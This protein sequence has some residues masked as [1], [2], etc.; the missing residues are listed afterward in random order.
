MHKKSFPNGL[1]ISRMAILLWIFSMV[2]V[3]YLSLAPRVEPPLHFSYSDKVGHALAYLWLSALPYV[4][5]ERKKTALFGSLLMI[6][7][8]MGLEF[9]QY[10]I[11]EREFSVWDMAANDIGV[12]LGIIS[13]VVWKKKAWGQEG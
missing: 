12:I 6:V 11:P 1:F 4:G 10:F 13:G 3:C 9:G 7:L 2:I 5:F 8:G